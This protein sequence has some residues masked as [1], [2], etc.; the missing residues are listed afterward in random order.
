MSA[1]DDQ[2]RSALST[3]TPSFTA[4]SALRELH[5]SMQRARMRRR[6]AVSATAAALLV[7]G[8]AGVF[9]LTATRDQTTL[10]SVTSNQ[11]DEPLPPVTEIVAP[12]TT[13]AA[14]EESPTV[15]E[16]PATVALPPAPPDEAREAPTEDA[17]TRSVADEPPATPIPAAPPTAAPPTA[18]PPTAAPPTAAPASLQ[19]ITSSCGDVVVSIEAGTVRI[20]TITAAPGFDHQVHDAGPTSI[21]MTFTGEGDQKCEIHAELKSSGLDVE[22]Q[23]PE[24]G[25]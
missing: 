1:D 7:G 10:R 19:T 24:T 5:P 21:E 3:G 15:I 18:A 14:L 2:I 13:V 17:K 9:A 23:N 22:V 8:G 25:R 20:V 11:F 12:S 4:H 16:P 6:L